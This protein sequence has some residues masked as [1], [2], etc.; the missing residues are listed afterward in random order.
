MVEKPLWKIGASQISSSP[1]SRGVNKQ[2]NW[3]ATT[4]HHLVKHPQLDITSPYL[5]PSGRSAHDCKGKARPNRRKLKR[6]QISLISFSFHCG[7]RQPS[8]GKPRTKTNTNTPCPTYH[9]NSRFLH[10]LGQNPYIGGVN[11]HFSMGFWGPRVCSLLTCKEQEKVQK[12]NSRKRVQYRIIRLTKRSTTKTKGNKFISIKQDFQNDLPWT[13]LSESML[14]IVKKPL[15]RMVDIE[16]FWIS[17]TKK[18]Y[19]LPIFSN[20]M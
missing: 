11:L 1:K 9:G 4:Y 5:W 16:M 19:D 2:N 20:F 8:W 14:E 7:G 13:F 17:E 6:P 15:W 18:Y 10:F 3:V 12:C